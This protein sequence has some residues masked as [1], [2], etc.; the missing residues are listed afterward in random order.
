M[1]IKNTLR[2]MRSKVN[3]V[4]PKRD[5]VGIQDFNPKV[6]IV[7]WFILSIGEALEGKVGVL[8]ARV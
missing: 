8:V 1:S 7:Q 5:L 4:F 2:M 6:I 3:L